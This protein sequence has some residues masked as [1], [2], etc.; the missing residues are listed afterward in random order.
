MKLKINTTLFSYISFVA[1]MGSLLNYHIFNPFQY[2][3]LIAAYTIWTTAMIFVR[4]RKIEEFSI[5]LDDRQV[6]I[7]GGTDDKKNRA[8]TDA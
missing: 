8:T 3:Q 1:L 4:V 2:K 7:K 5:D 6:T